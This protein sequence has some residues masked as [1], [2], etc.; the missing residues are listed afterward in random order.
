MKRAILLVIDSLGIGAMNDVTDNRREDI[1]SNT[2]LH[3]LENNSDLTIDNLESLGLI[4]TLQHEIGKF[5]RS[6]KCIYGVSKLRHWGADSFYGHYEMVGAKLEKPFL[7]SFSYYVCSIGDK[8]DR[9]GYKVLVEEKFN[10]RYLI[11]ND[12]ILISDNLEG[13]NGQLYT[14]LGSEES[15][16]NE[17]KSI[18]NIV[19]E[20]VQIPRIAVVKC[21]IKL[22]E[23]KSC[24]EQRNNEYIGINAE[25][26]SLYKRGYKAYHL[27]KHLN[28]DKTCIKE[29]IK[30]DIPITLIGKV[31]DILGN[32]NTK[33]ISGVKTEQIISSSLEE[34]SNYNDGLIFINVQETDLAAHIQDVKLY[35][36]YLEIIDILVGKVMKMMTED[37]ILIITGDHG[38]DPCIGHS[39]HTREFVPI[40]V[41]KKGIN[42]KGKSYINLG[43]RESLSDIGSTICDYFDIKNS[44][45]NNSFYEEVIL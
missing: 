18:G 34:I 12:S 28:D 5:K 13:E 3:V 32:H 8:L 35:G 25:S 7:S 16:I 4:N 41:Y 30:S 10:L 14:V 6:N 15:K 45:I 42:L 44:S 29:L 40:L 39:K 24:I 38:N 26:C 11:I 2:L 9:L 17:V 23:L 21:N 33:N 19:R 22:K 37:D 27:V 31:S 1:G 43:C 36:K 20:I